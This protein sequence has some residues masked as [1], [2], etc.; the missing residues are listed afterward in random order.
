LW[1]PTHEGR[2]ATQ[3]SSLGGAEFGNVRPQVEQGF[4]QAKQGEKVRQGRDSPLHWYRE[5]F[6]SLLRCHQLQQRPGGCEKYDVESGLAQRAQPA[7]KH[8][9]RL[10]IRDPDHDERQLHL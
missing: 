5:R 9:T 1:N 8:Q 10:G 4:R 2:K 6:N 7:S 3:K